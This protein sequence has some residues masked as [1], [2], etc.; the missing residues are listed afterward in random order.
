MSLRDKCGEELVD[1]LVGAGEGEALAGD[2]LSLLGDLLCLGWVLRD[3]LN[4]L[5]EFVAVAGGGEPASFTRGDQFYGSSGLGGD[6]GDAAEHGFDD[7]AAK[8]FGGG[9]GVGDKIAGGHELGDVATEAE[10]VNAV[11]EA[12]VLNL[13]V[14]VLNVVGFAE[15]GV[16]DEEGDDVGWRLGEGLEEDVLAFPGGKA[17]KAADDEVVGGEVEGLAELLSC[18]GIDLVIFGVKA[19]VNDFDFC[20]VASGLN[21]G[22]SGGL[23]VGNDEGGAGI[24]KG[25]RNFEVAGA[26]VVGGEDVAQVI[27]EGAT[28]KL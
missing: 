6:D 9:G 27:D 16:A 26:E 15:E 10:E 8:G 4:D 13:L 25:D 3:L 11:L 17:T 21:K 18:I 12:E 7:D 1:L 20:G 23:G 22:V 24:G 14:K 2:R 28:A 19:V 5:G